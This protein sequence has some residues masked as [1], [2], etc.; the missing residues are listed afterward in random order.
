MSRPWSWLALPVSDMTPPAREA[1]PL[2]LNEWAVASRGF[3]N[4][5]VPR[6]GDLRS[7]EIGKLAMNSAH[8][9]SG[10]VL[11]HEQRDLVTLVEI[12]EIHNRSVFVS[13]STFGLSVA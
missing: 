9:V 4:A 13:G 11:G 3:Q 6:F 10:P 7:I 8:L 1:H 5:R 2:L 12:I